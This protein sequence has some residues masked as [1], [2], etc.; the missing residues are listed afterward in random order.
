MN[1]YLLLIGLLFICSS[2][3]ECSPCSNISLKLSTSFRFINQDIN[4]M[5][6]SNDRIYI[7]GNNSWIKFNDY[8]K[9]FCSIHAVEIDSP[10][11]IEWVSSLVNPNFNAKYALVITWMAIG[12]N[13]CDASNFFQVIFTTD[14][15]NS[16]VIFNYIKNNYDSKRNF[17]IGVKSLKSSNLLL[18]NH[19]QLVSNSDIGIKGKWIFIVNDYNRANLHPLNISILF[20]VSVIFNVFTNNY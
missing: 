14:N 20:I 17:Y 11:K 18:T 1:Y 19:S 9:T 15:I 5:T 2:A 12:D 8:N 3:Q 13:K 16:F 6:I 4:I 10:A 7:N